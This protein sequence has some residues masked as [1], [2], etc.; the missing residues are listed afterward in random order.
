MAYYRR[1]TSR[2][3]LTPPAELVGH[4]VSWQPKGRD[5]KR[6]ARQLGHVDAYDAEARTLTITVQ[7]AVSMW[8]PNPER[9]VTI[10]L[11]SG[12][13]TLV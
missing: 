4:R 2:A 7:Q 3:P 1:N 6:S 13:F 11:S 12:P 5:G 8:Q 10:P 9:T